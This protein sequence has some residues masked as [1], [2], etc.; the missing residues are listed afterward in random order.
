MRSPLSVSLISLLLVIVGSQSP[1]GVED[2]RG[3][4]TAKIHE[5]MDYAEWAKQGIQPGFTLD[6]KSCPSQ[7]AGVRLIPLPC[8]DDTVF[9]FRI[10]IALLAIA[11]FQDTRFTM[12][13]DRL[14]E[15]GVYLRK[16]GDGSLY[17]L[18]K[19]A[20]L[21]LPQDKIYEGLI[22]PNYLS[23]PARAYTYLATLNRDARTNLKGLWSTIH[24]H[25]VGP[26][27][28][29]VSGWNPS[30]NMQTN[31][32][33]Q[34]SLIYPWDSSGFHLF[35]ALD[36]TDDAAMLR[37][38]RELLTSSTLVATK[39]LREGKLPVEALNATTLEPLTEGT[40]G[41]NRPVIILGHYAQLLNFIMRAHQRDVTVPGVDL[42]ATVRNQFKYFLDPKNPFVNQA[43][44][45]IYNGFYQDTAVL[46][47]NDNMAYWQLCEWAAALNRALSLKLFDEDPAFLHLAQRA[48][49]RTMDTLGLFFRNNR[50]IT[51]TITGQGAISDDDKP[52][53]NFILPYHTVD[54]LEQLLR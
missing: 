39:M 34:A 5:L 33:D 52:N 9:N 7:V 17:C 1:G 23:Y 2:F 53:I 16:S 35:T 21:G 37:F 47:W 25:F 42:L 26:Q 44:G 48:F 54:L 13:F 30:N 3:L 31:T 45:G 28:G 36:R 32:I 43:E 29:I 12:G 24:K 40:Y 15:L 50:P 14:A 10:P 8:A 18:P 38:H 22:A 19:R 4:K 11:P 46:V 49:L 41:E 20:A 51:A 6:A 27:G